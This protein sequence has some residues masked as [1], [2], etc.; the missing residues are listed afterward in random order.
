M[1]RAGLRSGSGFT[2]VEV[3]AAVAIIT[4][5]AGLLLAARER[6]LQ[7]ATET[8]S[9]NNLRQIGL[10]AL[11]YAGEHDAA[12]PSRIRKGPKWPVLLADYLDP[13]LKVY[14]EPTSR[15]TFLGQGAYP[16][17]QDR[18]FTSYV[19]NGFNDLGTL[20]EDRMEIRLALIERPSA[21]ILMTIQDLR[22]GNH[23]MDFELG[24]HSYLLNPSRIRG[25]SYYLFA[26]G[27]ARFLAASEY[28]PS[29]WLVDQTFQIP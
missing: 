29:L 21:I 22:P 18:N 25:G 24:E 3:L 5:L 20:Y 26:D 6:T 23:Y 17:D 2:L 9:L 28:N 1:I 14:A 7:R 4:L 15:K 27:A 10:A 19:F 8:R 16:L 12:L 11:Q 13:G